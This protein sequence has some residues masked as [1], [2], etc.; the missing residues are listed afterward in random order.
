MEDS[1]VVD[2]EKVKKFIEALS[3]L[4]MEHGIHISA[5]YEE[6]IDYGWEED[7]YISGVRP[8]LIYVDEQGYYIASDDRRLE[9][10]GQEE[11]DE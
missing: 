6:E 5:D 7:P 1:N 2:V 3:L 11:E 8:F 10:S 4:E 9:D